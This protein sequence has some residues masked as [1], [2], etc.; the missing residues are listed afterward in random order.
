[1]AASIFSADE[2][3]EADGRCNASIDAAVAFVASTISER[4]SGALAQD[5]QQHDDMLM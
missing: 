1:V 5:Q 4:V 2:K 3:D